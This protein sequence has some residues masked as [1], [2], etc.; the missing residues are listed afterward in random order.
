MVITSWYAEHAGEYGVIFLNDWALGSHFGGAEGFETK[1]RNQGFV[2]V[3]LLLTPTEL[4]EAKASQSGKTAGNWSGPWRTRYT[5][6]AGADQA[7]DNP[8]GLE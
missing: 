2:N 5:W 8:E 4:E 3:R 1:L 7:N 6:E